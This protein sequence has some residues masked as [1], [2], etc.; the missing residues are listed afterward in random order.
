MSAGSTNIVVQVVDQIDSSIAPKIREIASAARDANTYL[1]ALQNAVTGVSG[2]ANKLTSA[3]GQTKQPLDDAAGGTNRLTGAIAQLAGRVAGAEAG[4]GMLGGA[5]ARVGV[6]AGIAGPLI[7][8][9]LAIA[10]VVG[11]ILIYD[12]FEAAARKLRDTQIALAEQFGRNRDKLLEQQETLIGLTQGPMAKYAAELNDLSKKEITT[13][14]SNIT[15]ELEEQKSKW[16]DLVGAVQQYGVALLQAFSQGTAPNVNGKASA[17]TLQQAQDFIKQSELLR[18]SSTDQLKGLQNDLQTTGQKLTDL[19]NLESALEGK[20]LEIT[21][22]SRR[23]I[24][25]YYKELLDDYNVYLAKKKILETGAA[26]ETLSEQRKASQEELRQFNDQLSKL[27]NGGDVVTP[28]QTLSLRQNQ[29]TQFLDEHPGAENSKSPFNQTLDTLDKDVGNAQQA[30][31]RQNRSLQ[32]LVT[33]YRDATLASGAYSVAL[34]IEAEQRKIADEVNKIAP[35]NE[36]NAQTISVLNSL[37]ASR[38]HDAE[39]SKEEIAIYDQ[40]QGPIEKYNAAISASSI[41]LAYHAISANEAAIADEKA[42]RAKQDSLNPLNAYAIGLGHEVGLLHTYGEQLTVATEIDKVR[43]GLQKEGRDL[44]TAEVS[45]LT[46]LLTQLERQKILQADVNQLYVQ[47]AEVVSRAAIQQIALATALSKG[48]ISETQFKV[49]SAALNV[50]LADQALLQSKNATLQNQ[51][52]AGIGKYIQG[53]QGLAKGL[54][55]A[56]GQA[57]STIAD[58]AA[59]SLGRAIAYGQNLGDALTNVARQVVSDLL[60]AFIKLGIQFLIN[61]AI[62]DSIGASAVAG[63]IAQATAV[64][65][66]WA[67]AAAFASLASFGA[68][69]APAGAAVSGTVALTEALALVGGHS[70]GGFINGPGSGTSDSILGRLSNGEFVVNSKAT[71]ENRDWLESINSGA[72]AVRANNVSKS[73]STNGRVDVRVIHDGS[74]A[75][76]V[77]Q[78][79]DGQ[80]RIIAKQEAQAAIT[81]HVP[82]LVAAEMQNPNSRVAKSVT[83]FTTAT[84]RR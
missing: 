83:Q 18:V 66:A 14:I 26:G 10:T 33:K 53:Y 46:T 65:T 34:K 19:H 3:L 57:F 78:T 20:N 52:V 15:K 5:F 73:G 27:K 75:I 13:N 7:I 62:S 32:E 74:T 36:R 71:A 35:G 76:A 21:E 82:G 59:N 31:D 25:D 69:A 6:A 45:A 61:K 44:T 48:V 55:D 38:I 56:Y 30:I 16:N 40:F 54:S 58:G 79:D 84:R 11:A 12:K 24:Q 42:L 60:S 47:N 81:A 80:I 17:F 70:A 1:I 68:N 4:F 28:Q 63:T 2:G 49:A 51:L 9:A 43:Q 39:L 72:S 41:L 77:R 67:P 8:A 23:G 37:A 50:Q 29:R 64:S 22:K